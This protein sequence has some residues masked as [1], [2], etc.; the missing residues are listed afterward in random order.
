MPEF[1]HIVTIIVLLLAVLWKI[2]NR[3]SLQRYPPGPPKRLF[4]GNLEEIPNK[5][6]WVAYAEWAKK[7]GM[8]YHASE[9]HEQPHHS[10]PNEDLFAFAGWPF[11]VALQDYTEEWRQNRKVYQQTFRPDAIVQFIPAIQDCIDTFLRSLYQSPEDLM[12]HIDVFINNITLKTMYGIDAK[13]SDDPL[14]LVAKRAIHI[15]DILMSNSFLAVMKLCPFVMSVPRW[16][17]IIGSA[18]KTVELSRKYADDLRNLPI[19]HVQKNNVGAE[20]GGL[21]PR[22]MH[23]MDPHDR[24]SAEMLQ[25]LKDMASIFYL[26]RIQFIYMVGARV[27]SQHYSEF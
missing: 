27:Y 23:E 25:R 11:D 16:V 7:Y 24:K 12:G 13:G 15:F 2:Y 14:V 8:R 21:I 5:K 18:R 6:P 9:S 22:F 26:G 1:A 19:E 4:F 3:T 17:P 10:R 20:T